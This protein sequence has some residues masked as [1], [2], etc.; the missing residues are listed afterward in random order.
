[1]KTKKYPVRTFDDL[2]MIRN[3]LR[4]PCWPW[5]PLKRRNN[6]LEDKNLGIL[7]ADGKS[8]TVYHVYLFDLPKTKEEFESV[9]KSE[10]ATHE[11]ML[12]DGWI[13]D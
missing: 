1:M 13:V 10:Y 4:W 11:A 2:T 9:P 3:P 6:S 7:C 12:Q 8:L 5:L